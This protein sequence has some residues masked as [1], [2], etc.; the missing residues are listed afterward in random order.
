MWTVNE[1]LSIRK[2]QKTKQNFRCTL[3]ALGSFARKRNWLT[4]GEPTAFE[5]SDK[6]IVKTAEHSIDTPEVLTSLLQEAEKSA[7]HLIRWLVIGAFAGV[8]AAERSRLMEED[9]YLT[10]GCIILGTRVTK[11]SRR[12]V[13]KIPP[14]LQEWLSKYAAHPLVPYP[15]PSRIYKEI[16]KL[17]SRAGVTLAK[18][19]LRASAASYLL[20]VTE[21]AASTALQLGHSAQ[22]LETVYYQPCLREKALQWFAIKPLDK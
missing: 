7:P 5:S 17:E 12:R 22:E 10:E 3:V 18:N 11:T 9:I 8:R 19:G 16:K 6:P 14:N 15:D 1:F 13:V 4:Y 2:S 21:N 20:L